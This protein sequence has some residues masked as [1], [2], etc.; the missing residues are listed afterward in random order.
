MAL[1]LGTG[2]ALALGTGM[3]LALAFAV[4]RFRARVQRLG[5]GFMVFRP[6]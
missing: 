6:Q 2:M 3:A 5:L 4:F 1:A